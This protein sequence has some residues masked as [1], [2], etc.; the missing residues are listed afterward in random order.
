M[1]GTRI[2]FVA[3]PRPA[4]PQPRDGLQREPQREDIMAKKILFVGAGAVGSYIGSFLSRAG[5][6]VT[7]VDPWA[8][9]VEAIKARG[10][11]VTGPHDP[12]TARP[13]AMHIHEAA[14]LPADFD[15]AFVTMKSYDTAWA[16][17]LAIR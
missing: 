6:D 10:I 14:R 4:G 15:I 13:K 12:F 7:I 16:T 9:H 1:P 5:H 17:Q 2:E 3:A 11:A 8:E